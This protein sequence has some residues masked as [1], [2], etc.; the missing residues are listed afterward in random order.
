MIR[1]PS[2]EFSSAG[3]DNK[4][5]QSRSEQPGNGH[6]PIVRDTRRL[7]SLRRPAHCGL[8]SRHAKARRIRAHAASYATSP[9]AAPEG[10]R[11]QRGGKKIGPRCSLH[12]SPIQKNLDELQCMDAARKT[13][14]DQSESVEGYLQ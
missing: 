11:Q 12:Q 6:P 14:L 2:G 4:K 8:G 3:S 13:Q 7:G 9:K 10:A 5:K 1:T